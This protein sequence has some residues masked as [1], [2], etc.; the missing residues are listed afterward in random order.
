MANMKHA[1]TKKSSKAKKPV[2]KGVVKKT[3]VKK[4]A[5]RKTKLM[6]KKKAVA[7]PS[8]KRTRWLDDKTETPLIDDYARQL[9]SFIDTMADGRVDTAEIDSQEKRLIRLMK[10]V[11]PQ[12]DDEL[13]AQ[14]TELLCELTAYDLM[15]VL[16]EMHQARPVTTFQG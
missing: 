11:E 9:Q 5:N 14:V 12:L 3:T 10:K 2:K 6:A 16:H 15:Q 4:A 7:K 13:H 8:A 1:K